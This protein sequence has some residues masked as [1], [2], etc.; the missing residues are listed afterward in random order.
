MMKKKKKITQQ[1]NA[2][3]KRATQYVESLDD[4]K[5]KIVLKI[6]NYQQVG[7]TIQ[8]ILK[9]CQSSLFAHEVNAEHHEFLDIVNLLDLACQ[10]V[11]MDKLEEVD[12]LRNHN[13]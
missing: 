3:Q 10:L 4:D 8:S 13:L 5:V 2:A 12:K 9:V 6:D 7:F 1:Q 11:P